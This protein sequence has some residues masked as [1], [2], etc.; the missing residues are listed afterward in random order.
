[1]Y[2]FAPV[3]VVVYENP[4]GLFVSSPAGL[5]QSTLPFSSLPTVLLMVSQ[6]RMDPFFAYS[7]P[8]NGN[9]LFTFTVVA[10]VIFA[11]SPNTAFTLATP[12]LVTINVP[13][14][15]V[16]TGEPTLPG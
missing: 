7:E 5:N 12:E 14:L 4:F 8:K 15:F 13:T 6:P 11:P 10:S 1:V 2:C 9:W 3:S 16:S